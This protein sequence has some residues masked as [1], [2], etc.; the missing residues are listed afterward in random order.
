MVTQPRL[1]CYKLGM[2]FGRE[3][4]VKRFLTS[5][6]TGFYFAVVSEGDVGAGDKVL[7]LQRDPAS[8]TI[9]S[10]TRLYT[11]GKHDREGLKRAVALVALPENWRRHFQER[12]AAL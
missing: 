9:A 3:D 6:R 1:P 2:K 8:V 4:M 5:G 10:I 11:T 7:L 12:L